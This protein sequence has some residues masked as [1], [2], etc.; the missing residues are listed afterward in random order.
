MCLDLTGLVSIAPIA[1]VTPQ[2]EWKSEG[3]SLEKRLCEEYERRAGKS[4]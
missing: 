3:T 1:A 2:Q 4:Y